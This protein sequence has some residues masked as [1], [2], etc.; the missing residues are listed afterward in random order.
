[1]TLDERRQK[2][3]KELCRQC[4]GEYSDALFEFVTTDATATALSMK[5]YIGVKTLYRCVK[6]YYESFPQTL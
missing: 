6:K 1:M 2:K 3:I 5:Y 4:G